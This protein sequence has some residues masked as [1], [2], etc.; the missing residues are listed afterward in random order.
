MASRKATRSAKGRASATATVR[1]GPETSNLQALLSEAAD[2]Y[3]SDLV[4]AD[5]AAR[6]GAHF[7]RAA[8]PEVKKVYNAAA[9]RL[10]G[11]RSDVANAYATAGPAAAVFQA[12]TAREQAGATTR[13]ET[14]RADALQSLSDRVQAAAAGGTYAKQAAK[15]KF[16]GTVS[17]LQQKLSDLGDRKGAFVASEMGNILEKGADRAA[18]SRNIRLQN[19]LTQQAALGK[20]NQYGIPDSEWRQMTTAARQQVINDF[21]ASNKKPKAATTVQKRDFETAFAQAKG[22]VQV[23][24]TGKKP[25]GTPALRKDPKTGVKKPIKPMNRQLAAATLVQKIPNQAALSAALDM[26]Y[27]GRLS[28]GTAQRIH[29][30]EIKVAEIPGLTSSAQYKRRFPGPRGQQELSSTYGWGQ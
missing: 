29:D 24:K 5:A 20:I 2:D 23:L 8:K 10:A 30:Q 15:T 14:A 22:L 27:E 3:K 12:A 13:L 4:A 16:R 1:F 7:A 17:D 28:H 25:D 6:S 21:K 11:A 26:V 19:D 9:G 18:K